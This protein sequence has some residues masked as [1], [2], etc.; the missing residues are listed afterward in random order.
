MRGQLRR[1][2]TALLIAG[3]I[4]LVVLLAPHQQRPTAYLGF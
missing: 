3:L 1:L 4:G 2:A